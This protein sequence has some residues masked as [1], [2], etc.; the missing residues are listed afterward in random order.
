M[1][2]QEAERRMQAGAPLVFSESPS[3]HRLSFVCLTENETEDRWLPIGCRA[4]CRAVAPAFWVAS[5]GNRI[6]VL[7]FSGGGFRAGRAGRRP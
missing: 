1:A 7:S 5:R 4:G 2:A 3:G 6:P